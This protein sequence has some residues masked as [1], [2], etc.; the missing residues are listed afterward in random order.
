MGFRGTR[1]VQRNLEIPFS[2]EEVL[3]EIRRPRDQDTLLTLRNLLGNSVFKI[4]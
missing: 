1:C 4:H 2:S 3:E